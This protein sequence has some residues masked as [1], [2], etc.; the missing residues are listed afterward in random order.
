MSGRRRWAGL[1]ACVVVGCGGD[2]GSS[3]VDAGQEPGVELR[4]AAADRLALLPPQIVPHLA[5][6]DGQ[7]LMV[8]GV[9]STDE[10]AFLRLAAEAVLVDTRTGEQEELDAPRADGPVHV[11]AAAGGSEGFV[12]TGERC[13]EGDRLP[14]DDWLC[15]P[16]SG[17]AFLL[18]PGS[19]IWKEIPFA[20]ELSPARTDQRWTFQSQLGATPDGQVFA[21]VRSGPSDVDAVKS[22]RLLV[23]EAGSWIERAVLPDQR[24][25]SVCATD[26]AF[27]TQSSAPS[28][29]PTGDGTPPA[30]DLTLNEVPLGGGEPEAVSLPE[31]DASFGGVAVALGCDRSGPYLTSS[32]PAPDAPM[33]LF[34]RRDGRWQAIGGDWP[35]GIV[36]ELASAP[37]GIAVTS[38]ALTANRF[39]AHTIAANAGDAVTAPARHGERQFVPDATSGGF[40]TVDR[41]SL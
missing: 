8:G 29:P 30:A 6:A 26:D 22:T 36:H 38:M 15:S 4:G 40:V 28:D 32:T 3:D 25:P 17:T 10:P 2:D 19:R 11:A 39:D 37:D 7:L 34:G 14:A 16:G 5:A 1:L 21:L 27:Y 20:D 33:V 24:T 41:P 13:A 12:V 35:P 9:E 18:E 31:V 23:L